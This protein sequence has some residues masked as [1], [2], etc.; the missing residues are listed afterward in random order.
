MKPFTVIA[1]SDDTGEVTTQVLQA[2]D[3]HDAMRRFANDYAG[4]NNCDD[5]Q[6]ICCVTGDIP[7]SDIVCPCE[8]AAKAC[9]IADLQHE[10]E[11]D[12]ENDGDDLCD[13]CMSS[14]VQVSHTWNEKT[15]CVECAKDEDAEHNQDEEDEGDVCTAC[16]RD[17]L[18][19]SKDPCK[20]VIE[21]R[22]E[23]P[24]SCR[25]CGAL[26]SENDAKTDEGTGYLAGLTFHYCSDH[27]K[28]TH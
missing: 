2:E 19:C 24:V 11:G 7:E 21:D 9:Y 6:V 5:F 25:K 12:D 22:G 3:H 8:D 10:D 14:G 15:V 18:T 20:D 13:I 17:S 27:C 16:G 28:K 26:V 4:L 23:T 1:L